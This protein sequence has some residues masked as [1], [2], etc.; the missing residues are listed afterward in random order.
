MPLYLT[1]LD[2]N[3]I[4][5]LQSLG[6]WLLPIMRAFTVA[7]SG[8]G[9]MFITA[10]IIWSGNYRLGLRAGLLFS[11]TYCINDL[12]KVAL[13]R[14]RPFWVDSRIQALSTPANS[15]C[16]RPRTERAYILGIPQLQNTKDPNTARFD[17]HDS[18]CKPFTGLSRRSLADAGDRR[19]AG[20]S[21]RSRAGDSA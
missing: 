16:L 2:A 21:T 17:R 7:G 5:A 9:I 20:R 8:P 11:L 14:P 12:L 15:A 4:I 18:L 19:L 10:L 1:G 13:R 3:I 6:N